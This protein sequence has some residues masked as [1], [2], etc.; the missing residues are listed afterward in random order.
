MSYKKL[1][2]ALALVLVIS[3]RTGRR[4]HQDPEQR[5]AD[6]LAGCHHRWQSYSVA[7]IQDGQKAWQSIGG[8]EVGTVWGHGSYVAPDWSAD[9]L[10]RECVFILDRW[11]KQSGAA[12]YVRL[13]AE[14]Q[15]ALQPRLQNIMRRNTYDPATGRSRVDPVRAAAFDELEPYYAD[16]FSRG[17]AN[18]PSTR[19]AQRSRKATGR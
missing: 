13:D 16:V 19:R 7:L 4:G 17:R 14:Q 6:P 10:H 8:Q 1:W 15:A 3:F 12:N 11:A 9:W 2:I 5:P 18:M